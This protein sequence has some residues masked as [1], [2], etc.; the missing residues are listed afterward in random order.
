MSEAISRLREVAA[1]IEE[2]NN[3]ATQSIDELTE[4]LRA[5]AGRCDA[6]AMAVVERNEKLRTQ[7]ALMVADCEASANHYQKENQIVFDKLEEAARLVAGARQA[8]ATINQRA[9]N[10]QSAANN[11]KPLPQGVTVQ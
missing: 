10:A 1:H 2:H 4:K 8:L 9:Q 11:D 7:I 5:V 3:T 6:D